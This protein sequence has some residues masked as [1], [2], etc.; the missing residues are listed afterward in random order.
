M[1]PFLVNALFMMTIVTWMGIYID[2]A[3]AAAETAGT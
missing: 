2:D 1:D 3:K